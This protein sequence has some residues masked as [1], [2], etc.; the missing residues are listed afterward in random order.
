MRR[1]RVSDP[2]SSGVS[3]SLK[4]GSTEDTLHRNTSPPSE[5]QAPS[6]VLST[7]ISRPWDRSNT[8]TPPAGAASTST[9]PGKG[10][11]GPST[12]RASETSRAIGHGLQLRPLPLY[13]TGHAPHEWVARGLYPAPPGRS[14]HGARTA[15][16]PASLKQVFSLHPS[17]SRHQVSPMPSKPGGHPLHTEVTR[18]EGSH[19]LAGSHPPLFSSQG[20]IGWHPRLPPRRSPCPRCPAGQSEQLYPPSVLVQVVSGSHGLWRHSSTSM[21]PSL[22]TPSPTNPAGHAVHVKPRGDP[23][24]SMQAVR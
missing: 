22:P 14:V 5:V 11:E 13:P 18:R 16:P 24:T 21:H 4:V 2:C 17:L 23:G 9:V 20:L 8:P 19:V 3:C 12:V 6:T 1:L 15:L 7:S 10:S